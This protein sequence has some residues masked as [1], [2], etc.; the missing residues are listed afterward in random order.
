MHA[1]VGQL[2][3]DYY[4][5]C[6]NSMKSVSEL[7]DM[8]TEYEECCMVKVYDVTTSRTGYGVDEIKKGELVAA[9]T[10]CKKDDCEPCRTTKID[11]DCPFHRDCEKVRNFLVKNGV[12]L[13]SELSHCTKAFTHRN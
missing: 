13:T 9:A 6:V 11:S 4:E 12:K 3:K 2:L 5:E 7:V 8:M 10:V 1:L